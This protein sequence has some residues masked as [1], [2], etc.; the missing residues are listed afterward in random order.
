MEKIFVLDD[1]VIRLRDNEQCAAITYQSIEKHL[2]EDHIHFSFLIKKNGK[3]SFSNQTSKEGGQNE[4][5]RPKSEPYKMP[6][7]GSLKIN[8]VRKAPSV[9]DAKLSGGGVLKKPDVCIN[10][11]LAKNQPPDYSSINR[12]TAQNGMSSPAF[13]T[14]SLS[15]NDEAVGTNLCFT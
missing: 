5:V 12:V 10:V 1:D 9:P 14:P 6:H 13:T 4:S 8:N 7:K 3:E 15:R 2:H 11:E